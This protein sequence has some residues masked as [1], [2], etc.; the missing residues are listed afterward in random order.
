MK[1]PFKI[2][3]SPKLK[4]RGLIATENISKN[5]IIENCP[6]ILVDTKQEHN[7]EATN[8]RHYYFE[9]SNKYHAVVLGYLSM[10]N[11]SFEPNCILIYNFKNKTIGLKSIVDI[12]KGEELT[13]E[14]MDKL[15]AKK[16]P[17]LFDFNK[18]IK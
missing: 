11:H 12:K 3:V 14:Y 9:Y 7:L 13:Y 5:I 15:E 2:G 18:G 17:E 8:L 16:Y 6:V 10:V 1:L 4:I